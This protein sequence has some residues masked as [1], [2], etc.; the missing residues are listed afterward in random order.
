MRGER[1]PLRKPLRRKNERKS[2]G[3]SARRRAPLDS[4]QP[5]LSQ[6]RRRDM[7]EE[8]G[9]LASH[10]QRHRAH[11]LVELALLH[12]VIR[13]RDSINVASNRTAV[14]LDERNAVGSR[15]LPERRLHE[16]RQRVDVVDDALLDCR[17][18][19]VRERESADGQHRVA[20]LQ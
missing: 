15:R 2:D 17:F 18:E 3:K 13:S 4:H 9:Q 11:L 8:L 6:R 7:H 16:L 12:G 5:F 1:V 20:E 19:P 14:R 10:A